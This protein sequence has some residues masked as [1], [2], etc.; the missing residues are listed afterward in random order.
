MTTNF[1]VAEY[2]KVLGDELVAAFEQGSLA[3]TPGTVGES[4]ERAARRKLRQLLANG[5]GVGSGFVIDADGHVSRQQ[6]I[7]L[8]EEDICPVFRLND[9]EE[10]AFYPCEGVVAVGEV[11]STIGSAE[12]ADILGKIASVRRL[13]RVAVA[14]ESVLFPRQKFTA[15]RHYGSRMAMEP[16]PGE[17]YDQNSQGNHQI[18]GF[19]I[20]RTASLSARSLI[21]RITQ[22][23]ENE[24][25]ALAPNLIT[26]TDGLVIK[27]AWVDEQSNK[28]VGSAIEAT[29]YQRLY[30][31]N[32][33]AHLLG[34]LDRVIRNG[35]TVPISAFAEYIQQPSTMQASD[36]QPIPNG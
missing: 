31:D 7:I 16:G 6:D 20:A 14:E 26:T 22:F 28:I 19:A 8:F 21:L 33:L 27:P 5:I 29:G 11:K 32:P 12:A 36:Y 17:T 2:V 9:S 24:G 34:D 35:V 10:A 23:C 13:N 15:Y 1:S 3:P 4:R 30:V 18:W 25:R